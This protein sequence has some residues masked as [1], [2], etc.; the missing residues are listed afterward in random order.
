MVGVETAGEGPRR[1]YGSGDPATGS[2][3]G[4]NAEEAPRWAVW[5]HRRSLGGAGATPP[6]R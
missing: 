3:T 5:V 4:A 2:A 1:V 6:S